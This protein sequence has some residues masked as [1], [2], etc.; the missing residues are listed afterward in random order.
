MTLQCDPDRTP[1]GRLDFASR[2][3]DIP[4]GRLTAGG[5]VREVSQRQADRHLLVLLPV[6]HVQHGGGIPLGTLGQEQAKAPV[7]QDHVLPCIH[8]GHRPG[9][10]AGRRLGQGFMG[11]QGTVNSERFGQAVAADIDYCFAR[12]RPVRTHL[13]G[14]PPRGAG[15]QL[16][17]RL[18]GPPFD[19]HDP[20]GKDK[21][22]AGV[23]GRLPADVAD[24]HPEIKRPGG[25]D[26]PRQ[27][28]PGRL[29]AGGDR[30]VGGDPNV[31]HLDM[32]AIRAAE[33]DTAWGE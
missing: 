32:L 27:Q 19:Q 24:I 10:R 25:E 30:F 1:F 16:A 20:L 23:F 26:R 31:V 15:F 14:E 2:Q 11:D 28:R 9:R 22:G 3:H 29:Q 18:C 8:F 5:P 33:P 17:A 4:F 6:I 21:R 13:P 7:G 12:Y